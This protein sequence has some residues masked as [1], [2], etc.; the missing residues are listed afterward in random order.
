MIGQLTEEAWSLYLKILDIDRAS[1]NSIE[2][3]NKIHRLTD[4]T[5]LRYL[6]RRCALDI[7][8]IKKC[9]QPPTEPR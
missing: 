7:P 3:E 5:Y 2:R 6:R 4:Q 9:K 8:I 1:G